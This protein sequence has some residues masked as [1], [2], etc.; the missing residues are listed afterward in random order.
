M[1]LKLKAYWPQWFWQET[2]QSIFRVVE[3]REPT[4][5]IPF[6]AHSTLRNLAIASGNSPIFLRAGKSEETEL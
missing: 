2:L 6:G 1:K 5:E 4:V 3:A